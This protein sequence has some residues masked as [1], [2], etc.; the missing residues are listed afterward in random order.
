[1]Y[2]SDN[3]MVVSEQTLGNRVDKRWAWPPG[4]RSEPNEEALRVQEICKSLSS[5]HCPFFFLSH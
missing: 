2:K 5:S 1:M 3:S 4:W